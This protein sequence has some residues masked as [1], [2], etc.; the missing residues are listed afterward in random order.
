MCLPMVDWDPTQG[1]LTQG[2]RCP[3]HCCSHLPPS[4]SLGIL[5]VLLPWGF[6]PQDA[7]SWTLWERTKPMGCPH[8]D[9]W[10]FRHGGHFEVA[11]P[12]TAHRLAAVTWAGV[13]R[14]TR[15][16]NPRLEVYKRLTSLRCEAVVIM[17]ASCHHWAP[18]G[19]WHGLDGEAEGPP[20]DE[21][22][23]LKSRPAGRG[24]QGAQGIPEL[25]GELGLSL[26]WA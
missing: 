5:G 8:N 26:V 9:R 21:G 1:C 19:Q 20:W 2:S 7:S 13:D 10:S 17:G 23:L 6:A 12:P 22:L 14:G 25:R 15:E 4:L 18:G 16:G 3:C 11:L 24:P